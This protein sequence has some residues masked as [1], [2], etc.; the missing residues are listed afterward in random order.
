M[1]SE[2]LAE[3]LVEK[4]GGR[5][6]VLYLKPSFCVHME[7][8]ALAAVCRDALGNMDCE[9]VLLDCVDDIDLFSAL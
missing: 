5:V 6:V 1:C 8:E 7:A 3:S 4:V 2:E 9:V